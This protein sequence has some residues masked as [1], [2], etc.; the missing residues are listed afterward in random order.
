MLFLNLGCIIHPQGA[1][2]YPSLPKFRHFTRLPLHIRKRIWE[3]CLDIFSNICIPPSD[4]K[5]DIVPT[6]KVHNPYSPLL[7]TNTEARQV[8]L[9]KL[10]RARLY[11]PEQDMLYLDSDNFYNFCQACGRVEWPSATKHLALALPVT[12]RGLW[13]PMA[14]KYLPQLQSISIVLP[15]AYGIIDRLEHVEV[16]KPAFRVLRYLTD[17][18]RDDVEIMADYWAE[19]FD[20]WVHIVWTKRLADFVDSVKEDLSLYAKREEAPCWSDET[21]TLRLRFD[22]MCFAELGAMKIM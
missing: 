2:Q 19:A 18:E 4:L 14:I 15:E 11:N 20:E 16:P 5:L 22:V 17:G 1:F 12:D 10:P 13:L 3:C 8:A 9:L 6:L 21:N 7:A